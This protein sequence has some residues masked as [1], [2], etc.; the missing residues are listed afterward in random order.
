MDAISGVGAA[1]ANGAAADVTATGD[2]S[3]SAV[4]PETE[5][6]GNWEVF[7][8]AA[9]TASIESVRP[10]YLMIG[11]DSSSIRLLLF[12]TI[13][14]RSSPASG[15]SRGRS[16]TQS[17]RGFD[18]CRSDHGGDGV[19]ADQGLARRAPALSTFQSDQKDRPGE[20]ADEE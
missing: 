19:D 7:V 17:T 1:V 16:E 10:I 3:E 4:F 14:F 15:L 5:V 8:H 9:A 18:A 20:S 13:G 6:C 2:R 11:N 12:R